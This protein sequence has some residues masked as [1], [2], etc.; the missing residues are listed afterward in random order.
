MRV[1]R[2]A[3]RAAEVHR[4]PVVG[5]TRRGAGDGDRHAAHGVDRRGG[6]GHPACERRSRTISA[7][8]ASAIS[9]AC[10]RGCP[11][12]PGCAACAPRSS[13]RS[14]EHGPRRRGA[15]RHQPDVGRPRLERASTA[16]PRR[17][18]RGDD[19][20]VVAGARAGHH[21]EA[22]R[23]PSVAAGAGPGEGRHHAAARAVRRGKPSAP[24]DSRC[25]RS[26]HREHGRAIGVAPATSSRAAGSRGSRKISSAP[27]LRHGLPTV[28]TPSRGRRA[29]ARRDAQQQRLARLQRA[30]RVQ[31]HRRLRAGPA[32]EA[33]DRAVGEDQRPRRP[34]ARSSARCA[35]H[36][37]RLHE[38]DAR[39]LELGGAR[40]SRGSI[41]AAA[42]PSRAASPSTRGRAC[43]GMSMCRT[44]SGSSASHTALTI[45]GG[46]PT[47]ADSP[48]PFAPIG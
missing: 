25:G 2:G 29:V 24:P 44:P 34:G 15:A 1:R 23:P 41:T 7:R 14:G 21:L 27:P 20:R 31:A 3:A 22:S 32:D 12:R 37:E 28:R 4:A 19:D 40:A 35:R 13:R 33:L 43:S 39:R 38:R 47:V 16:R 36:H 46:E 9:S 11:A 48:I 26:R 10:G 17:R 45:A 5:R 42:P 18:L 8:I 6:T 30:Q